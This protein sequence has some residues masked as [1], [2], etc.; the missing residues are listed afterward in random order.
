MPLVE[1]ALTVENLEQVEP[2]PQKPDRMPSLDGLRGVAAFVVVVNHCMML[3][4]AVANAFDGSARDSRGIV[5]WVTFTPLHAVWAG[6]EAVVVFFVLSGFVLTR[7]ADSR[8]FSWRA[9]YP[10]RLLRLYLPVAGALLFALA[11]FAVAPRKPLTDASWWLN[12]QTQVATT[13]RNFA[14]DL[15]LVKGAE[16]L[17]PVLWSLKWEVI[18]SLLLPVAVYGASR[19]LSLAIVQA[20]VLLAITINGSDSTA[21]PRGG[22]LLYL[23]MFG[24]GALMA[25]Q[26]GLLTALGSRLTRGTGYFVAI[27]GLVLLT[28]S[29]TAHDQSGVGYQPAEAVGAA[30][31]VF[32]FGYW[33]RGRA[34]GGSRPLQ[35]LGKRSFSLYL[36]HFPIVI[37]TAFALESHS[38]FAFLI[39]VPL[40]LVFADLFFRIVEGPS[41][42]LAQ[43]VKITLTS[44]PPPRAAA[45]EVPV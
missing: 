20:A 1:I 44:R 11:V 25:R 35:W 6:S 28:L 9:Y 24:I 17:L 15:V 4:P 26:H 30:L 7:A 2:V 41:H 31:L 8:R 21:S 43:A 33:R 29:W 13:V 23:P 36:V 22:Y 16:S 38:R 3:V 37:G 45:D 12:G 5:W 10:S 19:R 14:H 42:R 40:A 27:A 32:A 18:F 34:V 39:A